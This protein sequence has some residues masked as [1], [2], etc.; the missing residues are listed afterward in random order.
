MK[1]FSLLLAFAALA[2]ASPAFFE[3][4]Q[5]PLGSSQHPGFDYDLNALRLVQFED[6]KPIWISELD[7]VLRSLGRSV[8]D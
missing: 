1:S 7:K 4:D 5:V 8:G 6:Q 2:T 3:S